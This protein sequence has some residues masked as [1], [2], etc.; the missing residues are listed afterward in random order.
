MMTAK[1]VGVTLN[2]KL[3]NIMAGE[4]M[5]PEFLKMNPQHTVPTF[6]DNGLILWESRAICTYLVNK[7]GKD[8]S[9]YPEDP[10]QRALVDQRL[11]FD[12]GTLYQRFVDYYFPQIFGKAPANPENFKKMED[13]MGFFN[14]FL[15]G[16]EWAA[17]KKLTVADIALAATVSTYEVAGFDLTKYPNVTKWFAKAKTTIP[18]YELNEAGVQEFKKF[19]N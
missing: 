13:A 3:T 4:N 19:F 8:H 12:M 2:L 14:T 5:A 16:S 9:L 1:A 18:G 11:Y 6:K 7:Y 17:G 10:Q 15:Q